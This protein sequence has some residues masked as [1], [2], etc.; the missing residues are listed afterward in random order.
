MPLAKEDQKELAS[1]VA[2]RPTM[3]EIAPRRAKATEGKWNSLVGKA[4]KEKRKL[5]Q[6][7]P[8]AKEPKGEMGGVGEHTSAIECVK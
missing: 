8:I 1:F 5:R 3:P 6:A 4:T 7:I 2:K